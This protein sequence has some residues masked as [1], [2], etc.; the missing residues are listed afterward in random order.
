MSSLLAVCA[1]VL[2]LLCAAPLRADSDFRAYGEEALTQIQQDLW[3]PDRDLYADSVELGRPDRHPAF[4]WG[5]GV[6]LS[7]LTLAAREDHGWRKPLS[8][9][10]EGLKNYWVK[11]DGIAGFDVLPGPK[12]VDRYYD[13][14]AWMVLALLEAYEDT[15]NRA[16]LTWAIDTYRFVLSGEDDK[17]GGGI[18]WHEQRKT[19][20][21]TCVNAPAVVAS[22][23]LY[24]ITRRPEYLENAKRIYAW[25]NA[26]LEDSDGL[27]WDN[28]AFDGRVERTKWSYNTALMLRANCLFHAVA[29]EKSYL[30][31][32][33]RI[34]K[35]ASARW[36]DPDN[37]GIRDGGQF[38]HLLCDAFLALYQEDGREEWRD[39]VSRALNFV[40]H[41]VRDSSGHYGHHWNVP[42][43]APLKKY[44]L[45]DQASAARGFWAYFSFTHLAS[46]SASR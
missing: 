36:V 13:D 7:A 6:Q 27:Y 46:T 1:A 29:G 18:Y 30:E 14:N 20:K 33:E 35:A 11:H 16:L 41:E 34:A 22:L 28:V 44:T 15:K 5:C 9:Y 39:T 19:S 21:N 32:A 42:V 3:M 43:T 24:R 25:T 2:L 23:R 10:L 12:P 37:G 45:L 26:H 8:R 4:M 40:H 31:E 38:A 17:L